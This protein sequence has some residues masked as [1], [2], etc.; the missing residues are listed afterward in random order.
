MCFYSLA[1]YC[2][3]QR[4]NQHAILDLN[5]KIM[6]YIN[7]SLSSSVSQVFHS[8]AMKLNYR[9]LNIS[10]TCFLNIVKDLLYIYVCVFVCTHTW[11]ALPV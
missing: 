10:H 9:R 11:Y 7:F 5:F 2:F 6:N 1:I 3:Y 4:P 8:S